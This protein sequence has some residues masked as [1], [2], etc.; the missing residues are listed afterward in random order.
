VHTEVYPSIDPTTPA[1]SQ[2]GKVVI[3]SGASRGIG[4]HVSPSEC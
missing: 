1:L 3:I 4:R 2:E